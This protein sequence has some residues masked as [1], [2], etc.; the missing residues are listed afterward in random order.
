M[1]FY[2]PF[3]KL[4]EHR[5]RLEELAMKDLTESQRELHRANL[6]MKNYYN[7]ID[8]S[9]RQICD[10]IKSGGNVTSSTQLLEEYIVGQKKRIVDFR[11]T[12]RELIQR[13]EQ[14]QEILMER[15]R[16][17]KILEQLKEKQKL[18]FKK[19]IKKREFKNIDNMVVMRFSREKVDE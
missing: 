18:K 15:A 5:K 9:R 14:K 13:V 8:Q 16:E 19:G 17:Y 11:E 2:F 1:K 4:M 3:E 12:V 7:S 6:K 10:F